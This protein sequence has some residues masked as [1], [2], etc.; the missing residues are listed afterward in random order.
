MARTSFAFT[1]IDN[2]DKGAP[3]ALATADRKPRIVRGTSYQVVF[4]QPHTN[5]NVGNDHIPCSTSKF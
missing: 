2:I 5:K 3:H 1:S 4:P